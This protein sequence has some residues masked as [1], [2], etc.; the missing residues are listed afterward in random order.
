L[1]ERVDRLRTTLDAGRSDADAT[2][3]NSDAKLVNRIRNLSTTLARVLHEEGKRHTAAREV[4]ERALELE[5][6]DAELLTLLAKLARTLN[7]LPLLLVALERLG[8]GKPPSGRHGETEPGNRL[9]D[10]DALLE[11][12]P[13]RRGDAP[14]ARARCPRSWRGR[15]GKARDWRR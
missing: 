2:L 5:P 15:P 8:V 3:A 12:P 14:I 6:D 7:D 1:S 13:D 9:A 10:P 4:V 11:A